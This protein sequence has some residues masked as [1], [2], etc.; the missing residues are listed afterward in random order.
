LLLAFVVLPLATCGSW[1]AYDQWWWAGAES[2]V[3]ATVVAVAAGRSPDGI[4]ARV[5]STG[6]LR[7]SV[8]FRQSYRVQGA[9]NFLTGTSLS[10]LVS[11]GAWVAHLRFA[12][13]HEY[14][15][16][17]RRNGGV[18]VVHIGPPEGG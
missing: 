9:D 3:H 13:G 17:A 16:E 18:W 11:P 10:D 7:P 4:V 14:H 12:N 2:A 5:D 8:D 15:A 6:E 1:I